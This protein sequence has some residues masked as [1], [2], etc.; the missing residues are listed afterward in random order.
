MELNLLST[1]NW[2][3]IGLIFYW[4]TKLTWFLG[5]WMVYQRPGS[6][7]GDASNLRVMIPIMS[8]EM[9]EWVKDG[10]II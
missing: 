10:C 7:V 6:A 5:S 9:L 8:F 3:A 2:Y 1:C 4:I